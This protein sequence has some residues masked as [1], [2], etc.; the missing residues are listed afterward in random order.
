MPLIEGRAEVEAAALEAVDAALIE[1][2]V[3]GW[4]LFEDVVARRAWLIGVFAGADE[5]RRRW[6]ELRPLLPRGGVGEPH[7]REL[8]DT[9]W[10]ES[11]KAHFKAWR[12]GR[13]HWV[14]EWERQSHRLPRGAAAVFLDPGLAFGTGN[15]ETTRL[16]CRRLVEFAR[17]LP[18][19]RRR[20]WR[21]IDAGCGSGILAISAAK[22]GCRHVFAFDH[23]AVAVAIARKNT[24]R[25]EVAAHVRIATGGVGARLMRHQAELVL[26]N[27]QA[28]VLLTHAPALLRAVA[29]G[30]RLVLSG[31]LAVEGEK[32]SAAFRRSAG[33]GWRW[34]SRRLGEW[35]DV[36]GVAPAPRV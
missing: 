3:A 17:A 22:L 26:A 35:V 34:Q 8:P 31:I 23:D 30:G 19:R 4:S 15:H 29:S 24:R 13:L 1:L 2:G 27:I 36:S 12:C 7:W 28:D 10:R 5:P 16:C 6:T 20:A 33:P 32:V 11:Y 25:N 9:D 14:P 18:P 21:V